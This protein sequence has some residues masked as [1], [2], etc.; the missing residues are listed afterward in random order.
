MSSVLTQNY[1]EL[2]S[3]PQ[4]YV[5]D[6]AVLDARYREL[7]RSVH[8]DRFASSSDQERRISMQQAAHIN[9]AYQVLKD[10]LKRGR[11]ML[12][13]GGHTVASQQVSHQDPAFLMQQMELRERLGEVREQQDPL[14]ALD[15][16]AKEIRDQYQAL[17]SGLADALEVGRTDLDKAFTLV[18]QMQFFTRLRNEIQELEADL[19]DELL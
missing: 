17:E 10:P 1:F 11:Y 6:R 19:E 4:R 5:V 3:L 18:Q 16:L 14:K 8:P 7:Q 15:Q 13:L 9:E 12:E 2:F